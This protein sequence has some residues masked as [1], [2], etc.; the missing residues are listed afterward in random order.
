M[1]RT[2]RGDFAWGELQPFIQDGA[3]RSRAIRRDLLG[4]TQARWQA[5]LARYRE[6]VSRY[7]GV[8]LDATVP[9]PE[10]AELLRQLA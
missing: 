7:Y 10:K 6:T 5:E 9:A 3:W 2:R 1:K 8:T 4:W